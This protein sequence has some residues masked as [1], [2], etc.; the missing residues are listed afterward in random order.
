M[1]LPQA[2]KTKTPAKQCICCGRKLSAAVKHTETP[3]GPIGPECEKKANI[4]AALERLHAYDLGEL[5]GGELRL[6]GVTTGAGTFTFP[7]DAFEALKGR[8]K[9]CGV[10]LVWRPDFAA[11]QFVVTLKAD[12]ISELLTQ[13]DTL[14]TLS[15]PV[16]G[17]V[18]VPVRIGSVA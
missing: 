16:T 10:R 9:D 5:A 4:A 3:L 2:P 12:S 17:T 11:R 18:H 6:D 7:N 13:V 8:A 15:N 1:T 14:L